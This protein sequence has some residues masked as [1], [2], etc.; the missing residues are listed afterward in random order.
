MRSVSLEDISVEWGPLALNHL[1]L[2]TETERLSC[3]SDKMRD[4]PKVIE[5]HS[6]AAFS[7]VKTLA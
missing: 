4:I 3:H 7:L 2:Y 1:R 5:L 6:D